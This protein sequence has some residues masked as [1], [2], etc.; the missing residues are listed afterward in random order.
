[1][2]RERKIQT[3]EKL[4]ELF[5]SVGSVFI[6]HYHGLNVVQLNDLRTKMRQHQVKFLVTKNNLA[7][8]GLKGSE[9]E[10][11]IDSFNGPVAVALSEDPVSAAKILVEFAKDNEQLKL[12]EA[13][14]FGN[15]IDSKGINTL[16]KM[17]SLDELRAKLVS[18]IQTPARSLA[19]ILVAPST[20]LARVLSV[21][22]NKQNN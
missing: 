19:S 12:V 6:T 3:V 4:K 11:L 17:P 18:L 5:G 10:D 15:K 22:S 1:M 9:F 21:Y 14:V 13:K 20:T 2:L 7:K 8:L 16:S